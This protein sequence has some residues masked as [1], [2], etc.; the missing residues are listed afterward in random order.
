[1]PSSIC[2]LLRVLA[3]ASQA[4]AANASGLQDHAFV[5][6]DVP[7]DV[8]LTAEALAAPVAVIRAVS[9]WPLRDEACC[10]A[11]ENVAALAE[12]ISLGESLALVVELGDDAPR[13]LDSR[14]GYRKSPNTSHEAELPTGCLQS[15]RPAAVRAY[16]TRDTI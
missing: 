3:A 9:A 7:K 8:L 1:M 14:Q 13:W 10:L 15:T 5:V 6:D 11:R 2:N 4:S 12:F 16:V